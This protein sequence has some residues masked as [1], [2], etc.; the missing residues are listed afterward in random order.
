MEFCR[1]SVTF[2]AENGGFRTLDNGGGKQYY[3]GISTTRT[4]DLKF[5]TEI[6]YHCTK[7]NECTNPVSDM[8]SVQNDVTKVTSSPRLL[9]K[10]INNIK[11]LIVMSNTFC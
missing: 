5:D 11:D 2:R 10:E 1:Y 9:Y 7:E 8:M 3:S 4:V 6:P